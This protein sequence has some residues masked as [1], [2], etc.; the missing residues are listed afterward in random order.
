MTVMYIA[1]KSKKIQKQLRLELLRSDDIFGMAG[2]SK[3]LKKWRKAETAMRNNKRSVRIQMIYN[4]NQGIAGAAMGYGGVYGGSP[5]VN[6]GAGVA[7]SNYRGAGGGV[8]GKGGP[9]GGMNQN[10]NSMNHDKLAKHYNRYNSFKRKVVKAVHRD[11]SV[12]TTNQFANNNRSQPN[13][14][15]SDVNRSFQ[16]NNPGIG[17]AGQLQQ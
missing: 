5:G 2:L 12:K 14:P 8:G 3:K 6:I 4:F 17:A 1:G 9:Q 13:R 10:I 7:S 11:C 15:N 16:G